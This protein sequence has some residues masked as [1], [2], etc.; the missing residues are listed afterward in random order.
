MEN[1]DIENFPTSPTAK[2]MLSRVSPIYDRSYV[3]K[4]LFQV[5]GAEM[6]EVRLRFDQLR[7]QAFPE[8]A[9]WALPYWEQRYGIKPAEGETDE[10]RRRAIITHRN[11]REPINPAKMERIIQAMTGCPA[12]VTE[13]VAPYTFTVEIYAGAERGNFDWDMIYTKLKRIKPSHQRMILFMST[14]VEIQIKPA[15][16]SYQFP[17]RLAGTH[18]QRNTLGVLQD[19]TV[20]NRITGSA[21]VFPYTSAGEHAAGTIP[22]TNTTGAIRGAGVEVSAEASGTS[23]DYPICGDF[24]L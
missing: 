12:H 4:W 18:P 20:E 8:T 9:T 11:A 23:F 1:F 6:D 13:N 3:G 2:R 14:D 7:D 22:D 19:T 17:Y 21:N 5:M 10:Q 15:R 16:T 24:N